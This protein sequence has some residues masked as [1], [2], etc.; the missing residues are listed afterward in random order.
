MEDVHTGFRWGNF[1]ENDLENLGIDG[2]IKMV[3]RKIG[4]GVVWT[5]LIWLM[6]RTCGGLL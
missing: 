4:W 6:I 3:L 5:G 1:E 2:R